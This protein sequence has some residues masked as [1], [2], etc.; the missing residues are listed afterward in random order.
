MKLQIDSLYPNTPH[1]HVYYNVS[2]YEQ[3]GSVS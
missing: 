2:T 1:I 3:L